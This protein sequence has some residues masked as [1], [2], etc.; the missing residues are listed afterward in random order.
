MSGLTLEYRKSSE[1]LMFKNHI[2]SE[3]PGLNDYLI[4]MCISLHLSKPLMYRD[5]KLIRKE[6][7]NKHKVNKNKEPSNETIHGLVSVENPTITV[8]F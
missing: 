4:D 6:M 5:K 1:Y 8:E 7:L 2:L 3:S